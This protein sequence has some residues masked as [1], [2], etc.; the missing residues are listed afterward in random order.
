MVEYDEGPM[1]MVPI[2]VGGSNYTLVMLLDDV[3]NL[4]RVRF[5]VKKTRP[6]LE[7]ELT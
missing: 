6:S 2:S 7:G 4:G 3:Q 5:Q 1:L